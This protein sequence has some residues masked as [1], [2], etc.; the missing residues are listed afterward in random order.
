MKNLYVCLF[1]FFLSSYPLSISTFAQSSCGTH[2]HELNEMA[3]NVISDRQKGIQYVRTRGA[4]DAFVPI[5]FHI[6]TLANGTGGANETALLDM[7]DEV[8]I[9]FKNNAVGLQFY[10]RRVNY[11]RSDGLYSNP[12]S[13]ASELICFSNKDIGSVNIFITDNANPSNS[14]TNDGNVLGYYTSGFPALSTDWIVLIRAE[15]NRTKAATAAHELGH[16]YGLPHTFNGW[17]CGAFEPKTANPI[18]PTTVP[19][20]GVQVENVARDGPNKN[21]NTAGDGFCDTPADYN[22]GFTRGTGEGKWNNPSNPC[23]YNGIAKDPF[24]QPLDPDERNLMSYFIGCSDFF[25]PEQKARMVSVYQNQTRGNRLEIKK[26]NTPQTLA[27]IGTTT[28]RLPENQSVTRFYN[29]VRIDWDDVPNAVGYVVEV[30][31]TAGF[32]SSTTRS[33]ISLPSE[34]ILTPELLGPNFL[35]PNLV[36]F[37]RVRAY[38]SYVTNTI[39][40]NSFRF[41]TGAV[42]TDVKEI[43]GVSNFSVAPNPVSKGQSLQVSFMSEKNFEAQVKLMDMAGRVLSVEKRRFDSGFSNQFFDVSAL[44]TGI[45]FLSIESQEGILNKKIMVGY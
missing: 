7:V 18:A 9:L 4:A 45:Y 17:E 22:F 8:N 25:S 12:R 32:T 16:Y 3:A 10:I 40:S 5:T 33:F 6:V 19:C 38:G 35:N 2:H 1:F 24:G 39:S 20:S 21:C 13:S 30:S 11:I 29:S 41:T 42:L 26:G 27:N 37:W 43:A 34:S 23:V 15:A 36:F 44:T 14:S 31:R 28:L